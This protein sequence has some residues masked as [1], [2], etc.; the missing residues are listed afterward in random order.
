MGGFQRVSQ[1]YGQKYFSA[2]V[3]ISH[4]AN[5]S[6]RGKRCAVN[7]TKLRTREMYVYAIKK[8]CKETVIKRPYTGISAFTQTQKVDK[9][10]WH[11][12]RTT[13]FHNLNS[14]TSIT[15]IEIPQKIR[16]YEHLLGMKATE[17]LNPECY[18]IFSNDAANKI[19]VCDEI[20]ENSDVESKSFYSRIGNPK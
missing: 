12:T 15:G 20:R 3:S 7:G 2:T 1:F 16:F 5:A 13:T 11:R 10:L 4:S 18:N 6:S 19:Q 9:E 17:K 8:Y 14:L